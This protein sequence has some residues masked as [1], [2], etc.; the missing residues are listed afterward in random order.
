MSH[1]GNNQPK[2]L[3][4]R[5]EIVKAVARVVAETKQDYQGKRLLFIGVLKGSSYSWQP[6]FAS[7]M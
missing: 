4:E 3:F 7:S 1:S 6:W 5:E 2:V